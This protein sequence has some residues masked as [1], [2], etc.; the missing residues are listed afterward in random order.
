MLMF[1]EHLNQLCDVIF[2]PSIL[3]FHRWDRYTKYSAVS[4][5]ASGFPIALRILLRFPRWSCL[6][7]KYRSCEP[8][9]TTRGLRITLS[10]WFCWSLVFMH[11]AFS[12]NSAGSVSQRITALFDKIAVLFVERA[13]NC[14][15]IIYPE[16][17][18]KYS[19]MARIL[20]VTSRIKFPQSHPDYP[21]D[22]QQWRTQLVCLFWDWLLLESNHD[23]LLTS[24]LF[25]FRRGKKLSKTLW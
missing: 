21:S 24:I 17:V 9:R 18:S 13:S 25:R 4:S 23:S 2:S 7:Y 8:L 5:V 3:Q 10:L 1:L 19:H 14:T 11:I 20:L 16:S 6:L 15:K 22:S 12:M